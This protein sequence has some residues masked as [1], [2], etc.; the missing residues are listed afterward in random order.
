M[1][2][3]DV[4][5][6]L[7]TLIPGSVFHHSAPDESKA[8]RIVWAEDSQADAL[9]GD[10][11]MKKQVIEGGIHLFDKEEYSTLFDNVQKSLNDAGIVFR[12]NYI[13]YEPDTKIFHYEWV[14][15]IETD[16]M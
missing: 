13:N 14:F 9:H 15:Q 5:D 4:R 11:R 1:N 10:G 6:A 2:L 16:V 12:L 8:P 7:K 3:R